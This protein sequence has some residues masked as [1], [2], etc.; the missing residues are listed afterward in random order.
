MKDR[1][2]TKAQLIDELNHLRRQQRCGQTPTAGCS[3]LAVDLART[4]DGTQTIL[5]SLLDH[6]VF[7]D[8][9]MRVLWPNRAACAT[10][11]LS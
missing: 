8:A 2:K 9:H 7:H 11:G 3:L 10:V 5:D 4:Q 1:Y 6:V